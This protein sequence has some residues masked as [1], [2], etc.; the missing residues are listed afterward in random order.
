MIPEFIVDNL[1][2]FDQE[3][4]EQVNDSGSCSFCEKSKDGEAELTY[5]ITGDAIAIKEPDKNVIPYLANEKGM[6]SCPDGF[7]F[8]KQEEQWLL[9]IIEF[10]KTLDVTKFHK[11]KFQFRMG[12][13]NAR[14]VA[15]FLG[16]EIK[17]IILCSSYQREKMPIS[18]KEKNLSLL[19]ASNTITV[20]KGQEEW[21]EEQLELEVDKKIKTYQYEKIKLDGNGKATLRLS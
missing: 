10:K 14:A 8:V 17:E 20:R 18:K 1:K 16:I 21:R 19:R 9:Y 15:A 11:S 3:K 4:Y 6:R 2:F 12:I 13:Y 5:H 7:L